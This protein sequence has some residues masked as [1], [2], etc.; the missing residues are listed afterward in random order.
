[1]NQIPE[2]IEKLIFD[3]YE[4]NLS[5]SEKVRVLSIIHESP[6]YSREF[7]AW[8]QSY[9]HVDTYLPDYRLTEQLIKNPPNTWYTTN[10]WKIISISSVVICLLS[11]SY[12]YYFFNKKQV[13]LEK[14]LFVQK[15]R[16]VHNTDKSII[17]N[18]THTLNPNIKN[19]KL[20]INT[21]QSI[22]PDVFIKN[23]AY[24][25][26]SISL[27]DSTETIN[28][29]TETE[30]ATFTKSEDTLTASQ[31]VNDKQTKRNK[32][33]KQRAPF[34]WRPTGKIIPTNPNF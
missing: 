17:N 24:S 18:S 6:A 20:L 9:V 3:Y 21:S 31:P 19:N 29:I 5:N 1:M 26:Q 10:A 22:T 15:Q 33:T 30:P 23:S 27:L 34:T 7:V 11:L 2:H 28:T 8:A 32:E 14:D 25:S 12:I 4:G 16:A 13:A